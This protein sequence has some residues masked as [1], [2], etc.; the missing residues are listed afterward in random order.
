MEFILLFSAAL[1]IILVGVVLF[2][3]FDGGSPLIVMS[4][5]IICAIGFGIFMMLATIINPLMNEGESVDVPVQQMN[6]NTPLISKIINL[7]VCADDNA[8]CNTTLSTPSI[9]IYWQVE[10]GIGCCNSFGC[11]Y[12]LF[13]N[14]CGT[15]FM[16]P[17]RLYDIYLDNIIFNWSSVTVDTYDWNYTCDNII[18]WNYFWYNDL[19]V[20]YHEVK[21]VQKD[22][23]NIIDTQ[24]INFSLE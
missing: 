10:N 7:R 23:V 5:V 2:L 20:G 11:N 12:K 21:I 24:T 16:Q 6:V 3:L 4:V 14:F 22:C 19:S 18:P 1:F 17:F 8:L 13:Q 15:P 9:Y